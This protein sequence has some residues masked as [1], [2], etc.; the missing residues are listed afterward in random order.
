M[1]HQLY[2]THC[3][4]SNSCDGIAGYSLRARSAGSEPWCDFVRRFPAPMRPESLRTVERPSELPRQLALLRPHNGTVALLH[5]NFLDRDT[6]GRPTNFFRHVLVDDDSAGKGVSLFEALQ[7]WDSTEWTSVCAESAPKT[8]PT[9]PHIPIPGPLGRDSVTAFLASDSRTDGE[10]HLNAVTIP[11]RL[12]SA[13]ERRRLVNLVIGGLLDVSAGQEGRPRRERLVL[14]AEPGLAVVLLACAATLL[15]EELLRD[16]TFTSYVASGTRLREYRESTVI[17]TFVDGCGGDVE[18]NAE[19]G[20]LVDTFHSGQ[21]VGVTEQAWIGLL[22]DSFVNPRASLDVPGLHEFARLGGG[23]TER[24]LRE[25]CELKDDY[26]LV[27]ASGHHS[28]TNPKSCLDAFRRLK[29]SRLGDAV[30]NRG[31]ASGQGNNGCWSHLRKVC[32]KDDAAVESF[33]KWLALP[34]QLEELRREVQLAL[35]EN[36]VPDWKARWELLLKIVP[37]SDNGHW[38]E[39]DRL[40]ISTSQISEGHL[41]PEFCLM[42]L[43]VVLEL[44]GREDDEFYEYAGRL[45]LAESA[46]TLRRKVSPQ[47][48]TPRL[49]AIAIGVNLISKSLNATDIHSAAVGMLDKSAPLR[50]EFCNWLNA[51]DKS[52]DRRI[53]LIRAVSGDRA[54][55]LNRLLTLLEC[56]LDEQRLPAGTVNELL[57]FGADWSSASPRSWQFPTLKRLCL[58]LPKPKDQT[59][60]AAERL[61]QILIAPL[62]KGLL[63]ERTES[64]RQTADYFRTLHR[65]RHAV[66]DD[67]IPPAIVS[68]LE[69]WAG[70]KKQMSPVRQSV[71]F[72]LHGIQWTL[73][74]V[75][76]VGGL[77]LAGATVWTVGTMLPALV[78]GIWKSILYFGWMILMS[79]WENPKPKVPG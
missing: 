15:P 22:I 59:I 5:S 44:R 17:G 20:L 68:E 18:V 30:L 2:F 78:V 9:R 12:S 65:V 31:G 61:W 42:L 52:D 55:V 66:G 63:W 43:N 58:A 60:W 35:D 57:A 46:D 45:M 23:L 16:V 70:L 4:Q 34:D 26:R 14:H 6:L 50:E 73:L 21:S 76:V 69:L 13:G 53:A 25:A 3:T 51:L 67:G 75:G 54:A 38:K 39:F 79:W 1:W 71:Q 74:A 8:L 62:D 29:D 32:L 49:R 36:R 47:H 40:G 28:H 77:G 72:V 27:T 19:T 7:T 37:K 41:S 10:H 24:T 64:E 33:R 11:E 48:V 56:G